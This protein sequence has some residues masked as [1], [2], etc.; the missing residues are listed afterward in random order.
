MGDIEWKY[1]DDSVTEEFIR[2]IGGLMGIKFPKD[3]IDCAKENHGA[4][5][6]PYCMDVEGIERVF[7]SLLSF[8]KESSDYIVNDYYNYRAT[9]PNCVVPFGVDPA[10]NLICFDYKEHEENPIVVFWEHEG[11]WEKEALMKSEGITEEE[12]EEVARENLFYIAAD[13]TEFLNKLYD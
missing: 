2:K 5:V 4:N 1:A 3:Y 6:M 12:A 9:L 8:D 11:A 7:G 13:F 10:G